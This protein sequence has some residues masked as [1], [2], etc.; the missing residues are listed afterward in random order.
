M[1]PGYT[2]YHAGEDWDYIA[3]MNKAKLPFK[4]TG[5][6]CV[7]GAAL[8]LTLTGCEGFVGEPRG[9]VQVDAAVFAPQDDYVYYP[10]YE[11]Y[12][13]VSRHQYAYRDGNRWVAEPKPRGVSADVLRASPSVPMNFHDSPAQHHSEVVKQYPKNWKPTGA[14][15]GQ[16]PDDNQRI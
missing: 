15:P 16:N 2:P 5:A 4:A 10:G 9:G 6:K 3:F 1:G 14:K 8:L 13:S 7:L 11:C 12:Y